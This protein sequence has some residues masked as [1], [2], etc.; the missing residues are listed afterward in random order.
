MMVCIEFVRF[1]YRFY[2]NVDLNRLD[3][4]EEMKDFLSM[5]N[6]KS[7]WISRV[8]IKYST[9]GFAVYLFTVAIFNII[10]CFV[11]YGRVDTEY[12]YYPSKYVYV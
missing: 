9:I 4:S 11:K 10:Y 1:S 12:L 3:A 7:E 2:L 8:C 6:E 5:V